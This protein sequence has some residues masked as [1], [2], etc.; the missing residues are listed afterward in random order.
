MLSRVSNNSH[1]SFLIRL[2]LASLTQ[3]VFPKSRQKRSEPRF[4][5]DYALNRGFWGSRPAWQIEN[6]FLAGK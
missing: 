4:W 3:A 5:R 6:E 2:C 1:I